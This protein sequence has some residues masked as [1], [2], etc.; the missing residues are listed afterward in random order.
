M[1]YLLFGGAPSTGKSE[2]ITRLIDYLIKSKNFVCNNIQQLSNKDFYCVLDGKNK[3]N[4]NIQ[5]LVTSA[6]DTYKIIDDFEAYLQNYPKH[7]FI[8]SSIRDA[9]DPMRDYFL[10]KMKIT[11]NDFCFEIPLAKITRQTNFHA[12]FQ[13]YKD[14]ID[15]ISIGVLGNLPFN[16]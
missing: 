14:K 16:I 7:D 13:W 4:K 11:K 8:I 10:K 3:N 9:G 1:D 5:V 15:C 6:T 2:T 12:A